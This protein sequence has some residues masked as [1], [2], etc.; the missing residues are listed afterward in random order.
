MKSDLENNYSQFFDTDTRFY[1]LI[2]C[3][4]WLS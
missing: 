4:I 1:R 2:Y 3:F